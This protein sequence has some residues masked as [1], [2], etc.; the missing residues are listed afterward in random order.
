[1]T[2][3]YS[4]HALIND[5]KKTRIINIDVT[6]RNMR[7]KSSSIV[8]PVYLRGYNCFMDSAHEKLKRRLFV[9]AGSITLG[10]GVIGIV[11]PVLPTTPFLLLAA[12]C[13]MRGSKRLYNALL[14]NRLI[15]N[16]VRNYLEG[17]GMSLK[18]KIW[19][20]GLLWIA[21][22]LSSIF[23]TE[24]LIIRITLAIVLIGVTIHIFKIKT[25][26]F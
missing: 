20:L 7:I 9:I 6:C 13:Y 17:R 23:A 4:T 1:M 22:L 26:R 11:L 14:G 24:S 16:Y 8:D 19:T 18:M 25:A 2:R 3:P 21:I 12:I 15:G 10:L 5:L